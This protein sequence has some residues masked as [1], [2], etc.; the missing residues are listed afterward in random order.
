[1]FS[2]YYE[3]FNV[4]KDVGGYTTAICI[5]PADGLPTSRY[6][7]DP[8]IILGFSQGNILIY[9]LQPHINVPRSKKLQPLMNISKLVEFPGCKVS[10]MFN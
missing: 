7:K 2:K 5:V 8:Q 1:M 9:S 6:H 3:E 4:P 10:A